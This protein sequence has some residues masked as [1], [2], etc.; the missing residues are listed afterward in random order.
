[1]GSDIRA[2][3]FSILCIAIAIVN[4]LVAALSDDSEYNAFRLTNIIVASIS[5]IASL[6]F[7]FLALK[8]DSRN[9]TPH[10]ALR[11]GTTVVIIVMF[12]LNG[13]LFY[14]A[15]DDNHDQK[16]G[17]GVTMLVLNVIGIVFAILA[18][19]SIYLC[20][21]QKGF[22]AYNLNDK[23]KSSL[24]SNVDDELFGT[25][26]GSPTGSSVTITLPSPISSRQ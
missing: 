6:I 13:S 9:K 20:V 10:T 2:W 21:E 1:M 18:M 19:I 26:P 25:S 23:P 17:K 4:V 3:V 15:N 12:V 22:G 8:C 7:I 16:M 14:F 5:I 24:N 11:T